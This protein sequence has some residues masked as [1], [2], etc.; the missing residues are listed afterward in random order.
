MSSFFCGRQ[1]RAEEPV[2]Q[3]KARDQ[4]DYPHPEDNEYSEWAV[5]TKRS[6]SF[7]F[8][9]HGSPNDREKWPKEATDSYTC[10]GPL[11][12]PP[13]PDDSKN[14]PKDHENEQYPGNTCKE[15]CFLI[16]DEGS[17]RPG[18]FLAY[19]RRVCSDKHIIT[20][21]TMPSHC[22]C[23]QHVPFLVLVTGI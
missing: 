2:Q 21:R 13:W 22:G 17:H 6:L 10:S 14:I 20:E 15:R 12:R 9:M 11:R 16:M 4:N 3:C 7:V 1:C 5:E 19:C 23:E 8:I 18:S